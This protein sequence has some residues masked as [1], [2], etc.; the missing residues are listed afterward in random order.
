MTLSSMKSPF[1][2][3][4]PFQLESNEEHSYQIPNVIQSNASDVDSFGD[5]DVNKFTAERDFLH[6]EFVI[7]LPL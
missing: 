2:L 3:M 5:F 6:A 1:Q 7:P 4:S